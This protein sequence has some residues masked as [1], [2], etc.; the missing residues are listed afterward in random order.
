MLL[1]SITEPFHISVIRCVPVHL[2]ADIVYP[3]PMCSP[4]KPSFPKFF[5][6]GSI[7]YLPTARHTC[8]F[9]SCD[10]KWTIYL[11]LYPV[12][13]IQCYNLGHISVLIYISQIFYVFFYYAW[14]PHMWR[15]DSYMYHCRC[16]LY[17]YDRTY[18]IISMSYSNQSSH[19]GHRM[20]QK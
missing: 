7:Q 1:A 17:V 19:F 5:T 10:S 14:H 15:L 2:L 9:Q 18:H 6:H 13:A 3:P 12:A 11:I 16:Y 4:S 8:P 20:L